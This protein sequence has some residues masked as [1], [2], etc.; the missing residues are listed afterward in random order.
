MAINKCDCCG[1]K[2]IKILS[3]DIQVLG[4]D[5]IKFKNIFEQHKN[6]EL[7]SN[8]LG[9]CYGN[10]TSNSGDSEVVRAGVRRKL[11]IV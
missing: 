1:E 10:Y 5:E 2:N 7:R 3:K 9:A 8:T 11:V 6:Y 4:E